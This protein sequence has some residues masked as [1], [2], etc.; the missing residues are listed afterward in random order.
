[1]KTV[2][3]RFSTTKRYS[4]LK[5]TMSSEN[6]SAPKKISQVYSTTL[7]DENGNL[8]DYCTL[9]I[10][11][12]KDNVEFSVISSNGNAFVGKQSYEDDEHW[13]ETLKI[14]KKLPAIT[15]YQVS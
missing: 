14:I 4:V 3:R 11:K 12:E 9:T 8:I 15:L 7:V 10:Y 6:K 13:E 1:M 2:K 5:I